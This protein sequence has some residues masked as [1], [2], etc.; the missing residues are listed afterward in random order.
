MDIY[1]A[2]AATIQNPPSN[3]A[4]AQALLAHYSPD[5]QMQL[6]AAIYLGRDHINSTEM[7]SDTEWTRRAIDHIPVEDYA[8]ILFEKASS[9]MT[10]HYLNS[11]LRCSKATGYDLNNM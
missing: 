11:L 10:T 4:Q 6:I 8:Q 2:I 9:N 7:R 5:V 1:D 3:L